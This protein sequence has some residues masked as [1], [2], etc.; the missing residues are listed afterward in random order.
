MNIANEFLECLFKLK[1]MVM[2][3][4]TLKKKK[5]CNSVYPNVHDLHSVNVN[6][7]RIAWQPVNIMK[8]NDDWSCEASKWQKK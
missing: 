1:D 3:K 2:D 4:G 6:F 8:V 5:K 7:W